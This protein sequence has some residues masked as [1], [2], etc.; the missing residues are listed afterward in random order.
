MNTACC[1]AAGQRPGRAIHSRDAAG[2]VLGAIALAL[3]P[4]CPACIAVWLAGAGVA[5]PIASA[6]RLRTLLLAMCLAPIVSLAVA[7]LR[8]RSLNT[9]NS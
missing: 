7:V 4:K 5:I 8:R 1:R 9:S 3:L 2:G 6:G